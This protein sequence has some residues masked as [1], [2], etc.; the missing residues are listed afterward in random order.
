MN[1]LADRSIDRQVRR[2]Q[3]RP[4]ASGALSFTQG[5]LVALLFLSLIPLPARHF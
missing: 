2:T 4:L 3:H 5:L 1:D